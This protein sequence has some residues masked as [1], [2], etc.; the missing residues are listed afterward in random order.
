MLARANTVKLRRGLIK[1]K[2]VFLKLESKGKLKLFNG[3]GTSGILLPTVA[4][5]GTVAGTYAF[6]V[7]NYIL[8]KHSGEL[9]RIKSLTLKKDMIEYFSDCP[10][11][12]EKIDNKEFS[13]QD[14]KAISAF[15]NSDCL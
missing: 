7:E 15:Y 13:K 9:K 3:Y 11:L 2:N 8:Q 14:I 10:K 4:M 1:K 6:D 12:F 5:V